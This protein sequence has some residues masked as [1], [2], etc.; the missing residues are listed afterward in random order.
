MNLSLPQLRRLLA[1]SYPKRALTAAEQ[2]EL[3]DLVRLEGYPDEAAARPLE[4]VAE[5]GKGILM[6]Y[7][8]VD[9]V[10]FTAEAA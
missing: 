4:P 10:D 7:Y 3:R 5:L 2:A 8:L 9:G 1:L 6:A